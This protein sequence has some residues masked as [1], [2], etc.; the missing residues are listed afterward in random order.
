MAGQKNQQQ[1]DHD[2]AC[3]LVA[4]DRRLDDVHR[5]WHSAERVYFEPESFRVAIQTAIQT[6]RTVT[7]ILQSNKAQ[8]PDFDVW[9]ASWQEKLKAIPLM[10][11]MVDARN[12][13]E[14]QGDLEMYSHVRAE[15]VASY[16]ND[17]PVIQVPANLFEGPDVLLRSL[18]KSDLG[19]HFWKHG[20]L[21]V[22]RRWVENSLPDHELLDAVATAYGVIAE[23][24]ADAHV[25]IGLAPPTT[26]NVETGEEYGSGRAGRLPCMVGHGEARTLNISLSDG[27]AFDLSRE[28][29]TV[30]VERGK[31]AATRYGVNPDDVFGRREDQE[32]ILRSLFDT[33]RRMTETDGHHVTMLVLLRGTTVVRLAQVEFPDHGSKY[34]VM[35]DVAHEVARK[36]ADGVILIG[37]G[38]LAAAD[39]TK[40]YMRAVDAPDKK[41]MLAATLVRTTG[42]PIQLSAMFDRQGDS[43]KLGETVEIRDGEHFIFAPVYEVWGRP[44]PDRWKG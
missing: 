12:K 32:S 19:D 6:L 39:P 10:R 33:A 28:E 2:S 40:P 20:T 43:V 37:E 15:L 9:Y 25:R 29:V 34:I 44:I 11:W 30:D 21:R 14:K 24:V 3:P 17:G 13:I 22:Q 38:W 16:L 26:T 4:V 31:E 8:I 7:F 18:P 23:I 1:G 41:E 35:R 5:H 42:E 36:G 27:R